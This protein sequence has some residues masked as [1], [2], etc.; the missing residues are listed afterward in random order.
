MSSLDRAAKVASNVVTLV[1]AAYVIW[2]YLPKRLKNGVRVEGLKV[3]AK[4]KGVRQAR[5]DQ[6]RLMW[7][8]DQLASLCPHKLASEVDRMGHGR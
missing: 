6:A 8:L 3:V 1:A 5:A 2:T 4:V 7:E